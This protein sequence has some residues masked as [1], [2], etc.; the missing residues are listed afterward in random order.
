VKGLVQSLQVSTPLDLDGDDNSES[1]PNKR[2]FVV[3]NTSLV[4]TGG[5][6][7]QGPTL[8]QSKPAVFHSR[9]LNSAQSNYPAHEQELLTIVDMLE[10]Y[11]HL[12]AGRK[13]TLVTDSQAIL[14]LFTQQIYL[15]LRQSRW[16]IFLNL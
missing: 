2:I 16:V 4:G 12:L 10:T 9:V 5:W 8:E 14:S 6:I 13:F 11:Y 1:D 7:S 15:S 3:T